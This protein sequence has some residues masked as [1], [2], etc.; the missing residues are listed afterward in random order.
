MRLSPL[1]TAFFAVIGVFFA[2]CATKNYGDDQFRLRMA[3][4]GKDINWVPSKVDIVHKMLEAARV[5]P[6]DI[7]YDLG[8][9]DGIITIEAARK[10]GVRAVGIEFNPDLVEL[11][12]RNAKRADLERLVSFRRGDIFLEDFS[13]A[14]VVTL[15][16][17]EAI[18]AKLMPRLLKMSPGTR[19]VSNTFGIE[20][21]V[22]D[23]DI[24]TDAGGRAY[25]WIVPAPVEG[26]WLFSG[27]PGVVQMA[28]E[29]RQKKQFFDATVSFDGQRVAQVENARV[30]GTELALDFQHG[31]R[32]YSL[33][34]QVQGRQFTGQLNADPSSRVVGRLGG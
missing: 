30:R 15:Y 2:G 31:G 27:V 14:T 22:P 5:G 10:Y 16:L 6:Q 12:R 11:S 17:G 21:W 7:V 13:E 1:L 9:G 18:N 23:Q 33:R 20:T 26:R 8:S 32:A 28:V 24:R 3:I 19:V 29:I 4:P 34:G 25:L